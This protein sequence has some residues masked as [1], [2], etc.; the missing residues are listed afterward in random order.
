MIR[1]TILFAIFLLASMSVGAQDRRP[2]DPKL[3]ALLEQRDS[4]VLNQKLDSLAK[5]EQE[6]DLDL[7]ANYY[8][9]TQNAVKRDEIVEISRQKFPDGRV[10]F[11]EL[12][13]RIYNERDPVENEK[14][15]QELVSRFGS[16]PEFNLDI[17]KYFVAVSFLGKGQPTK[18]REYLGKIQ[19]STYKT[20]AYSYAARESIT[21]KDYELGEELIRQTFADLDGDTTHRGMDEFSRIFSELLYINGKYEEGFPHAERLYAKQSRQTAVGVAQLKNTYLN[22]LIKLHKYKE[23][24]PEMVQQ[25]Q[26]GVASPLTKETFKEAYVA[27]HGSDKGFAE[28][29]DEIQKQLKAEIRA[30]VEK[31]MIRTDAYDFVLRDLDGNTVRLSDYKG[32]VVVLDFW[33][34]WCGPCKASFPKMQLAV[35]KYKDDPNVEFLF[36]HTWERSKQPEQDASNYVKENNYTFHVL[37]DTKNPETGINE[38]VTAYQVKGIP[39]KFVV[40]KKGVIRF[41]STGAG[42]VGEDA[43]LEELAFM[44]ELAEENS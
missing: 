7:L 19:N 13:E 21:A 39:A 17:S 41:Q 9:R 3:A 2:R 33:A 5:S 25:L 22:Y 8:N 14:N 36:I 1:S 12:T 16:R 31:K 11:N 18:V 37:M 28:F 26:A 35:D 24:Y 29:A 30:E 38:A 32:K 43:F 34:T 20:S 4:I 23:A 42:P 27:V 15:Y 40:D 44:I 10:A 6:G